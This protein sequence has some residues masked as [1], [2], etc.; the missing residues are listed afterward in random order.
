MNPRQRLEWII[1]E[2]SQLIAVVQSWNDNRPEHPPFDCEVEHVTLATAQQA[3]DEWDRGDFIAAMKT[4]ERLAT[5][6]TTQLEDE[7]K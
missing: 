4:M 1:H 5:Y 2:T 7:A 3:A 6:A